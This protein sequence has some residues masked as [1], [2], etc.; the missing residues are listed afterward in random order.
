MPK[1]TVGSV[2]PKPYTAPTSTS[3]PIEEASPAPTSV[4]VN[5]ELV[6][7]VAARLIQLADATY[8]SEKS[9]RHSMREDARQLLAALQS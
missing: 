3:D 7:A 5:V 8:V 2:D 4:M 9:T 6:K 1:K